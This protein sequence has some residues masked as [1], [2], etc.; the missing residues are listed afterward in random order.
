MVRN[1]LLVQFMIT[2]QALG[3]IVLRT[4]SRRANNVLIP[5]PPL[6]IDNEMTLEAWLGFQ[7]QL[8]GPSMNNLVLLFCHEYSVSG[9]HDLNS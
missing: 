9:P 2:E 1:F 6:D 7:P 5:P 4:A 3:M 8:V